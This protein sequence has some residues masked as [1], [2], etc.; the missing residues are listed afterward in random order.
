MAGKKRLRASVRDD[1]R[2]S[3]PNHSLVSR[4]KSAGCSTS[5]SVED[6]I[7]V[8][9]ADSFDNARYQPSREISSEFRASVRR[10]SARNP[11]PDFIQSLTINK[12]R[13]G[14]L[15]MYGRDKEKEKLKALIE[16]TKV[17]SEHRKR[18]LFL[19]KGQSGVGKSALARSI[20]P[21]VTR[22]EGRLFGREI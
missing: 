21:L 19:I 20:K 4:S 13:F 11:N 2:P 8:F 1:F 7:S 10:S 16:K 18:E 6:L 5:S 3:L 15:D 17:P 9:S 14:L 22:R 12:L